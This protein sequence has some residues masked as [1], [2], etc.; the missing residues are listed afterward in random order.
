MSKVFT[1][2]HPSELRDKKGD[3]SQPKELMNYSINAKRELLFNNSEL[4]EYTE[5][6]IGSDLN[7]GFDAF[8]KKTAKS[9]LDGM[10]K[11]LMH[12]DKTTNLDKFK[13]CT[14]TS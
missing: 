10:L 1:I 5:P 14:C 9:N 7:N 12:L 4:K 11:C 13:F 6:L 2:P 8:I 3:Y